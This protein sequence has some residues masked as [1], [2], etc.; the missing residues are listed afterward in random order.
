M[1][2]PYPPVPD[3]SRGSGSVWGP[4][5]GL[6][7]FAVSAG[8][9]SFT[10]LRIGLGVI[11]GL[12]MATGKPVAPVSSLRVLAEN[13]PCV[14]D[15][16]CP[17]LDARKKE[18]YAALFHRR[19]GEC[20]RLTDDRVFSPGEWVSWI[21]EVLPPETEDPSRVIFSGDG[22]ELLRDL[23]LKTLGERALFAPWNAGMASGVSV[24]LL[25]RQCFLQGSRMAGE[26]LIPA[27]IQEFPRHV[28]PLTGGREGS[29]GDRGD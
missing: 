23:I 18:V 22:T 3:R 7:G 4:L 25:G 19:E 13:L 20:H 11:K 14:P 29:G 16:L 26:D 17:M 8:P 15:F 27:Y 21:R 10:G 5:S 1:G 2:S 24:A 9:G 12:A 28:D 6:D